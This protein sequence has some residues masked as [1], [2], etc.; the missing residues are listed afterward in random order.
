[1]SCQGRA[2]S[3]RFSGAGESGRK[4]SIMS[5][6]GS[7]GSAHIDRTRCGGFQVSAE[8]EVARAGGIQTG[9]EPHQMIFS[10]GG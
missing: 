7:V 2:G 3:A 1:M 6:P 8:A 4:I 10:A 5:G 9:A